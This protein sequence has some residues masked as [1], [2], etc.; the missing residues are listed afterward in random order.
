MLRKARN[1]QSFQLTS[2]MDKR[3]FLIVLVIIS[4]V[5]VERLNNHG[6]A[7]GD[8]KLPAVKR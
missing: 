4:L 8:V 3:V 2:Y 6:E 1:M 5:D 7:S